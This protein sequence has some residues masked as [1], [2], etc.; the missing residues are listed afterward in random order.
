[1][2]ITQVWHLLTYLPI[3]QIVFHFPS[4]PCWKDHVKFWIFSTQIMLLLRYFVTHKFGY[5]QNHFC[6]KYET[7]NTNHLRKCESKWWK[8]ETH[9]ISVDLQSHSLNIWRI[10]TILTNNPW[11]MSNLWWIVENH[12]AQE[13]RWIRRGKSFQNFVKSSFYLEMSRTLSTFIHVCYTVQLGPYYLME[14]PIFW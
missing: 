6:V 12:V 5:C 7:N 2:L 13:N 9:A 10:H 14:L 8:L 3:M 4:F 11:T 1:M